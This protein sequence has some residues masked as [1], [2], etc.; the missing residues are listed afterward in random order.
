KYL[1]ERTPGDLELMDRVVQA[2]ERLGQPE[3]GMAY[4]KQ[5]A[6]GS[7][8][9]PLLERHANL[10]ARSGHDEAARQ[11]YETLSQ[12]GTHQHTY[13]VG[14]ASI[15][16]AQGDL[17]GALASLRAVRDT[18]GDGPETVAYWRLYSELAR[19]SQSSED[20]SF[21]HRHLLATGQAT[22]ADLNTLSYLYAQHPIDGAR[23]AEMQFQKDGSPAALQS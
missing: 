2:Y 20:A 23:I 12:I 15:D 3:Q 18:V 11:T 9:V 19:L 8:R 10:A 21:A 7:L 5:R 14:L 13:S 22:D 4:L 6:R 17:A 16:Y 1:S